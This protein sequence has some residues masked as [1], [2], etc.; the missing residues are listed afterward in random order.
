MVANPGIGE[1]TLLPEDSV[2]SRAAAV[3]LQPPVMTDVPN[4]EAADGLAPGGS[5]GGS[6]PVDPTALLAS[7]VVLGIALRCQLLSTS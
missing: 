2:A 6:I 4:E 7:S 3:G 1:A 5:C